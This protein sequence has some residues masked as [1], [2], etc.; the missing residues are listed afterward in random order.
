MYIK[1]LYILYDNFTKMG[2]I[3]VGFLVSYDYDLLRNAI[4][5]V[6]DF[7]DSIF[8]AIDIDRK[9]WNGES[10][11]IENDFFGWIKEIDIKDKIIIY[12]DNFYQPNLTTMQCEVRERKLLA[13]KMG[14]GNWIVQLD[15]DEYF[16]NFARFARF[17]K[18]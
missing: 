8:L 3:Q 6:Y 13:N 11:N 15:A 18:K 2:K 7:A 12:E 10:F 9:T 1:D 16:I 5:L 4:P 14:I 17:S